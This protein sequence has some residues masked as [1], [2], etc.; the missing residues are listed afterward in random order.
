VRNGTD[1]ERRCCHYL[2]ALLPTR[3]ER[4]DE[5]REERDVLAMYIVLGIVTLCAVIVAPALRLFRDPR[6][7]QFGFMS[8]RWLAE[9]RASEQP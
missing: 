9:H 5:A 7:R 1:G 6:G 8:E 4:R 3:H 2:E